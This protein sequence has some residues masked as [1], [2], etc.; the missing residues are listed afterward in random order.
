MVEYRLIFNDTLSDEELINKILL[1][2]D[3]LTVN[4][5]TKII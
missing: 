3:R 2:P 5:I 4:V 1:K